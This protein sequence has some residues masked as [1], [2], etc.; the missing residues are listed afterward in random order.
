MLS[1]TCDKPSHSVECRW[2]LAAY[3]IIGAAMG[4]LYSHSYICFHIY[5]V[6]ICIYIYTA[7]DALVAQENHRF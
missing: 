2:Q 3:H 4:D 7:L 1:T 6:R 5:I